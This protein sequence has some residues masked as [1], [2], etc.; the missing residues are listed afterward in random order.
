MLCYICIYLCICFNSSFSSRGDAW[1]RLPAWW[2]SGLMQFLCLWLFTL[3]PPQMGL[4]LWSVVLKIWAVDLQRGRQGRVW[5]VLIEEFTA[6]SVKIVSTCSPH[7]ASC[8]T[9]CSKGMLCCVVFVSWWAGHFRWIDSSLN[10]FPLNLNDNFQY[11]LRSLEA[12]LFPGDNS[13]KGGVFADLTFS[14]VDE[15][16]LKIQQ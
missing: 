3:R 4:W 15:S 5:V 16:P 12:F 14:V 10:V 1:E 11:Q 8:G 6:A 13:A 2:V 9:S 7:Q